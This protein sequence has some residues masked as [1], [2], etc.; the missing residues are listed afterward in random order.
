MSSP[1]ERAQRTVDSV[2][3][4]QGVPGSYTA[5]GAFTFT[6]CTI[7][8]RAPD[9]EIGGS[10]GRPRMQAGVVEIRRSE[11]AEPKKN[12]SVEIVDGDTLTIQDDPHFAEDDTER[13]VWLMTVA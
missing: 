12:G 8:Y 3:G 1:A 7:I 5:P 6:L 9:A 4:D 10:H 2:F 11:I 13:L